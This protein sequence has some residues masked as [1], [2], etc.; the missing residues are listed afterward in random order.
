VSF[1]ARSSVLRTNSLRLWWVSGTRGRK[2]QITVYM[3]DVD[4]IEFDSVG[5][6]NT[7]SYLLTN[8]RT[9]INR[10]ISRR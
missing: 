4:S 2:S 3:E 7:S 5:G 6:A 9:I 1:A 10:S 8:R